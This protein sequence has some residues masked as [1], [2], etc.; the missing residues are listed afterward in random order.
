MA[1][2]HEQLVA[3]VEALTLALPASVVGLAPTDKK[4]GTGEEVIVS[5][6]PNR[7]GLRITIIT[8]GDPVYLALDGNSP[9]LG[10]GIALQM[11]QTDTFEMQTRSFTTGEVRGIS[12]ATIFVAVQEF[13]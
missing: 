10:K 6:N 7:K 1:Q 5:A 4:I 2:W 12:T 13:E 9:E 11:G 8:P 3:A